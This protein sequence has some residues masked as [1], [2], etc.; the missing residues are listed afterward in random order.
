MRVLHGVNF[1]IERGERVGLVGLNG[2]GKTTL[3]SAIVGM[4]GWQDGSILFKNN[5][6][7]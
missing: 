3:I 2:H 4:T 7:G 6:I 5:E 1:F